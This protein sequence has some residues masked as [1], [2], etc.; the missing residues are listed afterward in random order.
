DN[1]RTPQ[2]PESGGEQPGVSGQSYGRQADE[3]RQPYAQPEQS[4]QSGQPGQ[5]GQSGQPGQA[6]QP[7]GLGRASGYGYG[8]PAGQ[9]EYPEAPRY[10]PGGAGYPPQPDQTAQQ[11]VT[12]A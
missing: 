9:E 5:F 6:E 1:D 2:Q 10:Y 7:Y 12:P 3:A 8:F 11:F 4:G